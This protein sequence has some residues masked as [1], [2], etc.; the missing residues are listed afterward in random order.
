MR[1]DGNI[2][3]KLGNS[4]LTGQDQRSEGA[5]HPFCKLSVLSLTLIE[6]VKLIHSIPT[7]SYF[8]TLSCKRRPLVNWKPQSQG[9]LLQLG[10]QLQVG[11]SRGCRACGCW[12]EMDRETLAFVMTRFIS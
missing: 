5:V 3:V 7:E 1:R 12:V 2:D 10:L 4:D 11:I 9:F 6:A 8:S